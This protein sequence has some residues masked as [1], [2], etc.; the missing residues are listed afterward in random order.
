MSGMSGQMATVVSI[1]WW[2]GQWLV[3]G[4]IRQLAW[5]SICAS[6]VNVMSTLQCGEASVHEPVQ[7][8]PRLPK[9]EIVQ[10]LAVFSR[11]ADMSS[12]LSVLLWSRCL[13]GC[14]TCREVRPTW[15][16]PHTKTAKNTAQ[17][18][19]TSPHVAPSVTPT[20]VRTPLWVS[21]DRCPSFWAACT[22]RHRCSLCAGHNLL[23]QHLHNTT[24]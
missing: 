4:Q 5:L 24:P 11:S 8:H 23:H 1:S 21:Y 6:N 2:L 18:N 13:V 22:P 15:P 17:K 3:D 9:R 20:A 19:S 14:E 7:Q 12:A 16:T 10:C